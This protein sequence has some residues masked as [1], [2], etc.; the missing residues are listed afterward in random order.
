MD[1]PS[2]PTCYFDS[3]SEVTE[4]FFAPTELLFGGLLVSFFDL[5]QVWGFDLGMS[6]VKV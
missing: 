6:D 3:E 1:P 2:H 5:P 4:C